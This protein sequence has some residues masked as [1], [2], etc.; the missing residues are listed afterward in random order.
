MDSQ[1]IGQVGKW[2]TGLR[3]CYSQRRI[4][5]RNMSSG[6]NANRAMFRQFLSETLLNGDFAFSN[7]P[8][9]LPRC[10]LRLNGARY[11]GIEAEKE[12]GGG[13]FDCYLL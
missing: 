10:A 2:K 11:G 8:V 9:C 7:R 3:G 1:L 6:N 5:A 12:C 4:N 13:D